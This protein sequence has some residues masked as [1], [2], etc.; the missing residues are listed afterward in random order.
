MKSTIHLVVT[1]HMPLEMQLSAQN[2]FAFASQSWRAGNVGKWS[3]AHHSKVCLGRHKRSSRQDLLTDRCNCATCLD[4][5]RHSPKDLK[6]SRPAAMSEAI[7]SWLFS[8]GNSCLL[9][10]TQLRLLQCN[11]HCSGNRVFGFTGVKWTPGWPQHQ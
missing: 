11:A 8:L 4:P 7:H 5:H 10:T 6:G 2:S 9:P 1:Q 3:L